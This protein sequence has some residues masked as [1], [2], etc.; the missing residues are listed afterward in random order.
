[1]RVFCYRI[2]SVVCFFASLAPEAHCIQVRGLNISQVDAPNNNPPRQ[3]HTEDAD[4]NHTDTM[5]EGY[6]FLGSSIDP[7]VEIV[8]PGDDSK[9]SSESEL[10]DTDLE[11]IDDIDADLTKIGG[12]TR[13]KFALN[14]TPDDTDPKWNY[15]KKEDIVAEES[16]ESFN[17][18][19]CSRLAKDAFRIANA[20]KNA[21]TR[22]ST[23]CLCVVLKDE[24]QY[25]KKFVFHNG[26]EAMHKSMHEKAVALNYA[27]RTGYQAHAE[28]EFIEFLLHRNKQN[29]ERYTHILGMGCSRQHCKECDCLLKLYLGAHYH[30]FTAAMQ[31][32]ASESE[33]VI[34]IIEE[35]NQDEG[36]GIRIKI[37]EESRVFQVVYKEDAI[38]DKRYPNYRLS[39]DMQREIQDKV[40]ML[41][42]DFSDNR[43]EIGDTIM[44][45]SQKKR[46]IKEGS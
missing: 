28:V 7:K 5:L 12:V 30:N 22:E 6:E 40:G 38:Q 19:L 42:L 39:K 20:H 18:N 35:L 46:K 15:L 9:Q 32:E 8:L 21:R 33:V 29:P 13:F 23:T 37:P 43:F 2:F 16:Q 36:D 3:Q 27:T 44:A 31:K 26:P 1:M 34:P 41:N 25:A 4:N 14:S 45:R 17:E 24:K 11:S 10:T